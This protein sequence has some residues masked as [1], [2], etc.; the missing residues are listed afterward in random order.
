MLVYDGLKSDFLISVEQDTIAQEI[1]KNIYEKLHRR[2]ARSEFRAW[3]NSM[4]YMYKVLND[5]DIPMDTGI[6][7]EYNIP[8]TSKRVDFLISGYGERKD[9]NMILIE[10]KQW[11]EIRAVPG[12][13]ALV[14]TYTGNRVRQVV[15]PS[16]QAWSY[17]A[18]LTDY[19]QAVR[20]ENISLFPCAY[21]H[22]YRRRNED[23]LDEAQYQTYLEEAPAF[24]RGQVERLR[25]FIKKRIS[26]GD[27]EKLI[28]RIEYGKIKPSKSLQDSI[29]KILAGNR[30]FIMLDEQKVVYEEILSAARQSAADGR[31]RVIIVQGGPGTGKSVVAINLLAQLTRE[32]QF[33]QY[34]S[35]NSA[36][37][38]V[39][40]KKLK[41]SLKK[42][43][44]DN[45]FKGSGSYVEAEKDMLDTILADDY[46]II[47]LS[48]KAA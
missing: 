6:A 23:P 22:N 27:K 38:N 21:L 30:E 46:G 13:D 1:E 15:H 5:Q 9:A 25:G 2:T 42:S 4:E 3:E 10:L 31:K 32:D 11:D 39:Y 43:S 24:T 8:R 19:N 18:L 12:V 45:L 33:C 29:A 40:A 20:K 44:I 26:Y 48:Q 7:I 36:P 17:A 34:V 35:K 41:G 47:G 14:E 16:Y 37:R 28:Y